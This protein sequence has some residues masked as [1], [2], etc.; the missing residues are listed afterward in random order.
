MAAA[1]ANKRQ[2]QQQEHREE[3]TLFNLQPHTCIE[4]LACQSQL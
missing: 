4:T 2:Q 1:A 3:H